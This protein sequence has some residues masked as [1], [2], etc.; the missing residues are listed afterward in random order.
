MTSSPSR[1]ASLDALRGL[2][3]LAVVLFH[4]LPYYDKLYGHG[5]ELPE[6][7]TATLLFGRYGVHLFFILSGFV[8]FMT[9]E[10]TSKAS[11][12][13]LARAFRLLPALWA[14]I[15]LTFLSVHWL[16]PESRAVPLEVAI[17]NTTLLHEYLGKAHVDGAYWSLVVEITFYSWMA[18]LFFSLRKWQQ[19]RLALAIWVI[20]CY[21][22]V[23]WWKQ[24]PP[25]L[26]FFIKDLLFVKYAPLFVAGM[27]IYRRHR[28]GGGSAFDNTLLALSIGH[29]LVAYK[30]PYSLFVLACFAVFA[31][32]VSGRMNWLSNRP[33]LWLGSLSYSLYL[34]H[35][36]IGYGVIGWS[37]EAGLPGWLGVAMALATALTLASLIHYLVEKPSLARFRAW[38][39]KAETPTALVATPQFESSV[40]VPARRDQTDS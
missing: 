38:R 1:L 36:N 6:A 29:G 33:M 17:L 19:L 10:R 14:A 5:F 4:Y 31:L 24:I 11:W 18:L 16:G 30:L 26:E 28:Y 20:A 25:A 2:A 34:V 23:L 22:G 32:A 35:Q 8:I 40:T 15:T 9:L 21:A 27:L 39:R 13:G 3:A 37:Y 12:F 7:A